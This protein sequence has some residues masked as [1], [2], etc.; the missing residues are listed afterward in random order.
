MAKAKSKVQTR[1]STYIWLVGQ[2]LPVISDECHNQLPTTAQVLRRLFYDLKANKLTLS[3]SCSM[4]IDEV[5][6]LWCMANIPTKQKQNAVAK[7]KVIYETHASISKNKNRRTEKQCESEAAFSK[8]ML[9]LFDVAH[10]E[11]ERIIK[12]KED[13]HF[14]QDQRGPRKMVMT[15]EDKIFKKQFE[16]KEKREF[17]QTRREEK[18][19]ARKMEAIASAISMGETGTST[20]DDLQD[21]EAYEVSEYHK[22]CIVAPGTSNDPPK[23]ILKLDKRCVIK[24]PMFVASLDRTVTS[25]RE[26]MYIIAPALKAAG[27]QMDEITL[28]KTSIHEARIGARKSL[29]E[30]VREQFTPATPLIAHFDGKLLPDRD[31]SKSDRMPIVVSGKD[32][33][34]LLG[35]PRLSTGTG[36]LMGETVVKFLQD[37]DGVPEWLAGL[38]FDT[39]ASNTGIHTGAITVIQK[40]FDKRLLFLACR[41]HILEIIAAAVFDLFFVSSGPQIAIFSRFKEE[42]SQLDLT[43]YAPVDKESHAC[44]LT[45]DEKQWLEQYRNEVISFL[46]EQLQQEKQPRHDYLEFIKLTLLTLGESLGSETGFSPPGAYHRARWMAKGIYVLKMFCFR[47]QFHLTAHELQALKRL[48]L[49]TITIY[50]QAWF[51]APLSRDAPVNDLNLLHILEAYVTVDKRVAE[52][53]LA[54]QKNH[55]WYLSEDLVGLSIFSDLVEPQEKRN[56]IAA[57]K[58]PERKKD[59]RRVNAK[60]TNFTSKSLS[61]FATKRSLNLFKA[62]KIPVA[63]L[64]CDPGA[65]EQHEDYKLARG[66]VSSMRVVNDCAERAVKLATDVNLKLTKDEE[67]QQLVYQVVEHHRKHLVAPA[68]K[69]YI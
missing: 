40:A 35:I 36:V 33:E 29:A 7:L 19:Q 32:V 47:E 23:K 63:L 68:K 67:Q 11:C 9:Q 57:F 6:E 58:K 50:V 20:P 65:W 10:A 21:D 15:G 18:E 37:W 60:S 69:N 27:I 26:A 42:W 24:D 66:K 39:T 34:K 45:T 25:S 48:C 51:K 38:C 41:H 64:N 17:E 56:I 28:S 13:W 5:F 44:F 3:E 16:K 2:L 61:D 46:K 54:K 12:I 49:F 31:G 52:T 53:A 1:L 30:E 14:L 62:L 4:A 43:Q 8:Q 22:K 55:L 59:L